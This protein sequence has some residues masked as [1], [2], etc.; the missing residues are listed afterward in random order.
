LV[1]KMKVML[2]HAI[3][4]LNGCHEISF[5]YVPTGFKECANITIRSRSFLIGDSSDG[6]INLLFCERQIK[7][8][9]LL[10]GSN[11]VLQS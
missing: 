6:F 8:L 9:K 7:M 4:F 10:G 3:K 2:V 1:E 11:L 5:D